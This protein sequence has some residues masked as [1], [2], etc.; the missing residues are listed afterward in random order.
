MYDRR[1]EDPVVAGIEEK[2]AEWTHLPPEYGEPIQVGPA[3]AGSDG[4]ATF[5]P[6]LVLRCLL[7]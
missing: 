2:I 1:G 5:P 3:V 7:P 6:G 4:R